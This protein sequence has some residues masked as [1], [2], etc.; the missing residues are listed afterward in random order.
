MMKIIL[1]EKKG[2]SYKRVNT[3]LN[4]DSKI[5]KSIVKWCIENIADEDVY[6]DPED[7]SLGR[8]DDIHVTVLYGIKNN[9]DYDKFDEIIKSENAFEIEI[10]DITIFEGSETGRPY[11]VVKFDIISDDLKKLHNKIKSKIDNDYS[12]P[13]YKPHMTLAYVKAGIG[14]KYSGMENEFTGTKIS[15]S[16]ATFSR[17]DKVKKKSYFKKES[18]IEEAASREDPNREKFNKALDD[19]SKV[20]YYFHP[21]HVFEDGNVLVEISYFDGKLRLSSILTNENNRRKGLATKIMKLIIDICNKNGVPISLSPHPFGRNKSMNKKQLEN[22]YKKLGFYKK[23]YGDMVH[24]VSNIV[25]GKIIDVPASKQKYKYDCGV[26]VLKTV[27]KMNGE[28][29]NHDDLMNMVKPSKKT[30]ID[31]E[32]LYNAILEFDEEAVLDKGMSIKK[33]EKLLSSGRPVITTIRAY[34]GG[35]WVIFTGFD[36]ENFYMMDPYQAKERKISRKDMNRRWKTYN[37]EDDRVAIINGKNVEF[38]NKPD[39]KSDIR[40]EMKIV[41]IENVLVEKRT[42]KIPKFIFDNLKDLAKRILKG[43]DIIGFNMT[44]KD[45]VSYTK[46]GKM[47]IK[48]SGKNFGINNAFWANPINGVIYYPHNIILY[49]MDY[50]ETALIHEIGHL[51]DKGT[52]K[53]DFGTPENTT[54]AKE[55]EKYKNEKLFKHEINSTVSQFV[56]A[57]KDLSEYE[58]RKI[59]DQFRTQKSNKIYSRIVPGGNQ[60]YNMMNEDDKRSVDQKSLQ[61]V[62]DMLEK[63][64]QENEAESLSKKSSR[65]VNKAGK[66]RGER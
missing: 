31:S 48:R 12:W 24:D 60:Y 6:E 56:N 18:I 9:D 63:R 37:E 28:I 66:A 51:I 8:E 50:I 55:M 23:K 7:K 21:F 38:K 36:D 53:K 3:Q 4:I 49:P 41:D 19:I 5:S 58:L 14:S 33:L 44:D 15:V 16:S 47:D 30:G 13:D 29:I 20:S 35:H 39:I 1:L 34:E 62:L 45:G 10:G 52:W 17:T 11:D 64:K 61:S 25:E 32:K 57:I 43:E 2:V 54:I 46:T 27:A 42:A 65:D 59:A 22:W 26:G 40:E